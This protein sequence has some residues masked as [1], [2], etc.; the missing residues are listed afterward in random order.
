LYTISIETDFAASHQLK[1]YHGKC[2]SLHGHTWKVR[3]EVLALETDSIGISI[4]F[5][6]LRTIAEN[7]I[8]KIDHKHLNEVPPFDEIN[9]TAENLARTIYTQIREKLPPPIRMSRVTV[10]ESVRHAVSYSE[11]EIAESQ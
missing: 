1:G 2:R 7:V 10:W 8:E 9:P 4:D 5:R 11:S 3:V 6:K